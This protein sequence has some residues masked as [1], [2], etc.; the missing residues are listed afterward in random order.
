MASYN[1]DS[2]LR[3][4]EHYGPFG[5]LK[6][7]K[8]DKKDLGQLSDGPSQ[9]LFSRGGQRWGLAKLTED[10]LEVTPEGNVVVDM[11]DL[12][13]FQAYVII[14]TEDNIEMRK[15]WVGSLKTSGDL[16]IRTPDSRESIRFHRDSQ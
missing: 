13:D 7:E 5:I 10:V 1:I 11:G 12:R 4:T 2:E 8:V 6:R 15:I 16:T 9:E 3:T 14:P